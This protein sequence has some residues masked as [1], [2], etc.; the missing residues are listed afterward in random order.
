MRISVGNDFSNDLRS[1]ALAKNGS[2]LH[3]ALIWKVFDF[4]DLISMFQMI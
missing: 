1:N 4:N 2:W 3:A